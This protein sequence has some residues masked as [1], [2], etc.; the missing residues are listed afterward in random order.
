M[1][2]RF[3]QTRIFRQKTFS[4]LTVR[5]N[6]IKSNAHFRT[7]NIF[8]IDSHGKADKVKRAFSNKKHY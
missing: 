6:E 5:G 1:E 7:T 4:L 8:S 3:F 2:I